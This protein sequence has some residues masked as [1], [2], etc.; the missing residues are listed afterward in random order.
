MKNHWRIDKSLTE[1]YNKID[2]EALD[3]V[4]RPIVF[5]IASNRKFDLKGFEESLNNSLSGSKLTDTTNLLHLFI[6]HKSFIPSKNMSKFL[7]VKRFEMGTKYGK[8]DDI[9]CIREFQSN[10][11]RE[12]CEMLENPIL[13]IMDDDLRFKSLFLENKQVKLGYP[14]SYVHE[15]YN[16]HDN[17]QCDV[18]LGGVTGSPPLPATSC[19]RTFL[20]DF[21]SS[22]VPDK[23]SKIWHEPDYYYD[24]SETRINWDT[25]PIVQ[26]PNSDRNNAN[27]FLNQM[28]FTCSRNRPLILTELPSRKTPSETVIRGGNTV[29]YNPKYITTIEHPKLPRR[30]DSIWAVLALEKGAKILKFSAPLY[31]DRGNGAYQHSSLRK[32]MSDDLFGASLQRAMLQNLEDFENILEKRSEKQLSIIRDCLRLITL[33]DETYPKKHGEIGTLWGLPKKERNEFL[34]RARGSLTSLRNHMIK[35]TL[36]IEEK[37]NYGTILVKSLRYDLAK[38]MIK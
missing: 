3:G 21:L 10:M 31:H 30:G 26:K 25:W 4:L 8:S 15:I 23:N 34:K 20:Q 35:Y 17:Y 27:Y 28:F 6:G 1:I 13:I 32:R 29:I 33:A 19:M 36:D 37:V 24:L 38:V 5:I 16:F 22:G 14:Y 11:A 18:A 9:G 12:A 7:S 2:N